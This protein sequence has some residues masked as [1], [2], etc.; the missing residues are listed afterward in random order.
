MEFMDY[1]IEE[2][3]ILIPVLLILGKMIKQM[4]IVPNKFIPAMLLVIGLG[5][6]LF[7]LGVHVEAVVQGVL[8]TGAA[9]FGHQLVKQK[10]K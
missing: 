6:S 7:L 4:D 8:I 2:A 9:V 3:L 5:L 10:D 1:I